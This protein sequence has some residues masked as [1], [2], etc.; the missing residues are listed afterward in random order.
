MY[1][2]YLHL[3]FLFV[4]HSSLYFLSAFLHFLCFFV[5][6]FMGHQTCSMYNNVPYTTVQCIVPVTTTLPHLTH[7]VAARPGAAG[8]HP[9]LLLLLPQD[10][11][12]DAAPGAHGAERVARVRA[13]PQLG[14]ADAR[15]RQLR[16]AA[17][18][19]AAAEP[20]RKQ[21]GAAAVL[22]VLG[23]GALPAARPPDAAAAAAGHTGDRQVSG[24]GGGVG[25]G[26]RAAWTGAG[27]AA[28][29]FCEEGM[30]YYMFCFVIVPYC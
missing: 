20:R 16:G 4:F 5:L 11:A 24:G 2:R 21:Q 10:A 6:T 8:H 18:H 1:F 29:K 9:A 14:G 3:Y 23:E 15:E 25:S 28:K 27:L 17:A 19:Q 22:R 7:V 26:G 12:H 30:H 13:R